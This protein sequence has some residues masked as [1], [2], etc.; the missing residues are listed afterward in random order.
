M[1][2][3]RIRGSTTREGKSIPQND[4]LRVVAMIHCSGLCFPASL[5]HNGVLERR[6][7]DVRERNEP[8]CDPVRSIVLGAGA[9]GAIG[10][11]ARRLGSER[12]PRLSLARASES[13]CVGL[14]SRIV[15]SA[16]SLT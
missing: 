14:I 8:R 7:Y 11:R 3:R 13:H 5:T 2:N 6:W 9:T 12:V 16:P 4:G 10:P 1:N 15:P